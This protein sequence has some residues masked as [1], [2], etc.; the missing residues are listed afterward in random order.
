[1]RGLRDD[2]LGIAGVEHADRHHARLERI[3]V[4]RHDRLDGVDDLRAD[5]NGVDAEMRARGVGADALDVDRDEIGRRHHGAGADAELADRHAGIIVHAVDLVDLEARHQPV[6]DHGL[7]AGAALLG[8]L[9]DDDRG[10]GE[11][12]RLGEIARGAEQHGGVAVMAAGVHL[13]GHRRL[14]RQSG[15]LLDRQRV[16][17]GAQADDLVG[18]AL[19]AVDDADHPGAA[20][21]GHHLV[22][23]E[24]L[25]LV[26]DDAGGAQDVVL[27]FRVGMQIVPPFGDLG[28][29]VGDAVD[30]RHEEAPVKGQCSKRPGPGASST[31]DAKCRFGGPFGLTGPAAAP[32]PSPA[33]RPE[34]ACPRRDRGP[35]FG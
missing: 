19:A 32:T 16:H 14:V 34:K 30:D 26:G 23:A 10:A 9:E 21:A 25:E 6:L 12:A 18:F 28:R 17:V 8:R 3:D 4:A 7:A 13:A 29:K 33:H 11:I 15:F 27:Q 1:M 24:G 2:V 5:Q 35:D 31:K 20:E 22:A